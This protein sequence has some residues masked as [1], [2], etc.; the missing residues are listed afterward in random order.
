MAHLVIT[1]GPTRQFLDPVRYLTNASSGRMGAA[2]AAAAIDLGHTVTIV[3][4]PVQVNYPSGAKVHHVITTE[5]MLEVTRKAFENADGLIG[6][7]APCDYRPIQVQS[8]KMSKTG[9][10]VMLRLIETPDI[11][12]TLGANKKAHQ[13]VVGFALET[14]D[15][16]FKAIVK[17]QRKCCD[18]MVSNGPMAIDSADNDVEILDHF[19][20]V[21]EAVQGS[22]ESVA[23][24]ILQ[25][26]DSN[27]IQRKE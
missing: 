23:V 14:E 17:M 3:S 18:M 6:A 13:W 7:A 15:R 9:E 19:G 26:V 24:R 16:R 2:L 27:L 11:I 1:S 20:N 4:G 12:A 8:Q 21:L 22:K 5:E 10:E 25:L